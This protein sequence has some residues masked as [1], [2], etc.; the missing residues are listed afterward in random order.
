MSFDKQPELAELLG[1]K[2]HGGLRHVERFMKHYFLIAKEVGD[3]TRILCASLE[4]K[5]MKDAPALGA[6]VRPLRAASRKARLPGT[7]DFR[8]EGG[9]ARHCR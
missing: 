7:P 8:I 6:R 1:Y 4:A 5:E 2:A 3:L 9:R